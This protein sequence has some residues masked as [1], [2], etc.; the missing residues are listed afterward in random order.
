MNKLDRKVIDNLAPI[1]LFVYSRPLHTEQ[2]L[3]ALANNRLSNLSTLYIYCDGP[4]LNSSKDDLLKIQATRDIV[5]KKKWCKEVIIYESNQNKGLAQSIIDGVTKVINKHEKIIVLEDDIIT[6]KSFLYYLNYSLIKYENNAE[7]M[8]INAYHPKHEKKLPLYYFSKTMFCWGWGTWKRAWDNYN[9]NTSELLDKLSN[10]DLTNFDHFRLSPNI[11]LLDNLH[12][13]K[14]TWAVK[15]HSQIFISNCYCISTSKSYSKNIGLDGTGENCSI[16]SNNSQQSLNEFF[17]YSKLPDRVNLK[18][19]NNF[20]NTNKSSKH[21]FVLYIKKIIKKLIFKQRVNAYNTGTP[22]CI[23]KGFNTR[24]N[25]VNY[26]GFYSTSNINIGHFTEIKGRIVCERPQVEISIGYSTKINPSTLICAKKIIIGNNVWISWGCTI[27]DNDG[28][29]IDILNRKQDFYDT[30]CNNPKDWS[31]VNCR[32]III[33]DDVW[34]GLNCII[35]KGVEIGNGAIIGAG[36]VVTKDVQPF[37][38][39]AGNPARKI[40]DLK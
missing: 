14:R 31:M 15:W 36:S 29:N 40:K 30:Y 25:H 23:Q 5:K 21:K 13:K 11:Q 24:I 9:D 20:T 1:V 10:K 18:V 27:M 19:L 32:D 39:V 3:E 8:H 4:K 2:T 12:E 35:L 37:T 17:Y 7:V 22:K 34:I 26:E 33:G 6:S 38:L 28:H 16:S